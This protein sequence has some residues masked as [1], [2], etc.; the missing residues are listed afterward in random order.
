M[1]RIKLDTPQQAD[2]VSSLPWGHLIFSKTILHLSRPL[3]PN[4][5]KQYTAIDSFEAVV[6]QAVDSSYTVKI[7]GSIVLLLT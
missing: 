6:Q 2:K 5:C 4:E 7:I 3:C 1:L